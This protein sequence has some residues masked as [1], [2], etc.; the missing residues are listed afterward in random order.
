MS[1]A[2]WDHTQ[3]T[4]TTDGGGGGGGGWKGGS[5]FS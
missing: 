2:I 5:E 3:L 4:S 1:S